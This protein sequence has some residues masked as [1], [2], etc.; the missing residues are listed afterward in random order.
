MTIDQEK[1]IINKEDS[2]EM[3][4]DLIANNNSEVMKNGINLLDYGIVKCG[5]RFQDLESGEVKRWME[6]DL[7][8]E[9]LIAIMTKWRNNEEELFQNDEKKYEEE[10][11][12]A[13]LMFRFDIITR[14]AKKDGIDINEVFD[15]LRAFLLAQVEIFEFLTKNH[16]AQKQTNNEGI[17][18]YNSEATNQFRE[19]NLALKWEKF[20]KEK[21]LQWTDVLIAECTKLIK[22]LPKAIE[23]LDRL[24]KK[25]EKKGTSFIKKIFQPFT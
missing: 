14:I 23:S 8:E 21:N 9:Q 17:H 24:M 11:I 10:S 3:K 25:E 20:L 6:K 19:E 18:A 15:H 16:Q 1:K 7:T 5:K 13:N 2:N 4:I 22:L 12:Y